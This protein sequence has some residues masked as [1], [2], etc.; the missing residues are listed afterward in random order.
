MAQGS[1]IPYGKLVRD[2]IPEIIRAG[3]EIPEIRVLGPDDF[4]PALIAK[5]HEEAEEL[6]SAGA[7]EV[8][9]E[10]ADLHEVLAALTAALGFTAAEVEAAAARKR[11]ERGGFTERLWLESTTRPHHG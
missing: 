7:A 11:A 5:L 3:G 1:R 4:V 10:L 8:L 9:G 6:G 2:R